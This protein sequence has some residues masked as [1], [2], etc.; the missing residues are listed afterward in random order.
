MLAKMS[1]SYYVNFV[2]YSRTMKN[3]CAKSSVPE[4]VYIVGSLNNF[5]MPRIK[6]H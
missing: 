6:R 1:H 5:L 3:V 2:E 4:G